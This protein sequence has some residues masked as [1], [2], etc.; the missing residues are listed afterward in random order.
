M[1]CTCLPARQQ[2]IQQLPA[3]AHSCIVVW[4]E[5]YPRPSWTAIPVPLTLYELRKTPGGLFHYCH[6][7]DPTRLRRVM[8]SPGTSER[9]CR[10]CSV[11]QMIGLPLPQLLRTG[12]SLTI[13]LLR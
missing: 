8:V 2:L 4:L 9:L 6:D 10:H 5:M 13:M 7:L 11:L 3:Q 1:L 12:P